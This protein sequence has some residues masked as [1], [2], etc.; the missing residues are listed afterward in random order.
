MFLQQ[1]DAKAVA[2]AVSNMGAAQNELVIVLLTGLDKADLPVFAHELRG[3]GVP[4]VGAVVPGLIHGNQLAHTGAIL[5]KVPC[6]EKP[7][8]VTGLQHNHFDVPP[9]AAHIAETGI[10]SGT[11]LILVDGLSR[12]IC[13]FLAELSGLFGNTL[14]YVGGGAGF[15]D[16]R[17][18]HCLFTSDGLLKNAAIT[19]VMPWSSSLGVRHGYERMRGPI[20][21]TK[22]QGNTICELN[23][24]NAFEVY[25]EAIK[26][27]CGEVVTPQNFAQLSPRYPFGIMKEGEEDIV[28]EAFSLNANGELVC[29]GDIPENTVLNILRGRE[30]GLI[31]ASGAAAIDCTSKWRGPPSSCLMV[32]C[33]SRSLFLGTRYA[34]ELARITE[35]L[36]SAGACDSP[37]GFL[38]VGEI[39]SYGEGTVDFLNKTTVISA[40]HE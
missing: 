38:S 4:F 11:A 34:E 13:N 18:R 14:R 32:D 6:V 2:A 25:A 23:W 20:V 8:I 36:T 24:R 1:A 31:A 12:N 5:F 17:H 15:S 39:A 16:F 3:T 21:A 37:E 26:H 28:R 9:L 40:F 10:V 27:A 22:T 29:V 19:I 30:E 35:P 33:V 7:L